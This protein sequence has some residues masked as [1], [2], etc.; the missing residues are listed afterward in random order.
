MDAQIAARLKEKRTNPVEA[1]REYGYYQFSECGEGVHLRES[2]DDL[3]RLG[4]DDSPEIQ[5]LDV[6]VIEAAIANTIVNPDLVSDDDAQPL[7]AWWWHLGKIRSKSYP[8]SLLPAHL[9]AVY[10][11]TKAGAV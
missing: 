5:E 4:K 1:Y 2:R 8:L 9:Q 10:T 7:T 3:H 11:E 6:I